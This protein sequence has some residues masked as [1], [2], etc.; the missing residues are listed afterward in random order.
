MSS[1]PNSPKLL[2]AGLVLVDPQSG[3]VRQVI[4]LQYNPDSLSRS[5]QAH[6]VGDARAAAVSV[7]RTADR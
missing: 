5:F 6:T 2:K 7:E 4:S 3:Q 1:F